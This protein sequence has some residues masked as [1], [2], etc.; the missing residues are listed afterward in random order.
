[1]LCDL[2]INKIIKFHKE[3]KNFKFVPWREIH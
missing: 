2:N 1:M 3:P